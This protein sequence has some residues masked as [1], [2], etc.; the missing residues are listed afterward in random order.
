M[1]LAASILGDGFLDQVLV[2]CRTGAPLEAPGF[3]AAE[4][5]RKLASWQGT[6]FEWYDTFQAH[7]VTNITFRRCGARGEAHQ[8]VDGCGDGVTG[9]HATSSVWS[10]L[11]H[12]DEHVPEFMQATAGVRYEACGR[13][14]R[15]HNYVVA[16]GGTNGNGMQ[17]TVSERYQ[18][19]LDADGSAAGSDRPTIMASAA[20]ESGEWWQLDGGCA[21]NEE[22]PLW[23]CER[24]GLRQLG[25]VNLAWDAAAHGGVGW[26]TCANGAIGV[27]CVPLGWVTHWGFGSGLGAALPLTANGQITGVLGGFG[28]HISFEAGSPRALRI[29]RMQVSSQTALVLSIP[30]PRSVTSFRIAAH[31]PP[32]C[33][34]SATRACTTSFR[35]V[36]S[37]QEVRASAGDVYHWADGLLYLRLVQPPA[38]FTGAPSWS[39]VPDSQL[40][41]SAVPFR[42]HAINI[43][44]FAWHAYTLIEAECAASAANPGV[45]GHAHC[46]L[47]VPCSHIG[48]SAREDVCVCVY[49]TCWGAESLQLRADPLPP[50]CARSILR[51]SVPTERD[52]SPAVPR[53]MVSD[54]F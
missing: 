33:S 53:R 24:R 49:V 44:R 3:T 31:A 26:R 16:N 7:I 25:S 10:F 54:G 4:A 12:S 2:R 50:S 40:G 6:G 48:G 36:S 29:D 43:F 22:G 32:W 8:G 42:R 20:A 46:A 18:S 30:Y 27:P 14:F 47:R 21:R 13:R 1:G 5:P 37:L 17:S 35:P 23:M 28:W 41:A 9:C 38:D 51:R 39:I 19:W 11:T 45:H 52:A 15:M 34:A